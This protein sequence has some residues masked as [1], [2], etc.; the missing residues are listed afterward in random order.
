MGDGHA[1]VLPWM[2]RPRQRHVVAAGFAVV[3]S[4]ALHFVAAER[5]P[6]IPIGRV[7][8][9]RGE[10]RYPELLLGDV[11]RVEPERA[12]RPARFRPE[13]PRRAVESAATGEE[14]TRFLEAELPK[15]DVS[16]PP[17]AGESQA[18]AEPPAA[19]PAKSWEARQEILE[20]Q[21]RIHADEISALPR[22]YEAR[23]E[24]AS[25][26]PDIALPS[27]PSQGAEGFARLAAGL[28]AAAGVSLIRE[29][30]SGLP[31]GGAGADAGAP[32]AGPSALLDEGAG[33]VSAMKPVEQLLAL[34]V[35]VCRPDSEPG[36]QF[37]EVRIARRTD[38]GLPVQA[39]DVLL[40]QDCSESM[41]EP[42]L[43]NCKDGLLRWMDRLNPG[44][45]FDLVGF[46]ENTYRCFGR[47]VE[48]SPSARA[49]ANG[50]VNEMEA[51]GKTDVYASLREALAVRRDPGRPLIA[52]LITD[53][54]PTAGTLDSSEIIERFT[55]EN[56]GRVAFFCVGGGRRV[57]RFLLDLLAYRNRGDSRITQDRFEIP[58]LMQALAAETARP[59]LTDLSYRFAP[60]GE[61]DLYPR[62]LAH[63]YLDRP[64]ILYGRCPADTARLVCQIVGRAG[65]AQHDMVFDLDLGGAKPADGDLPR[66][67]AWQRVYH[68]LGEH[69]QGGRADALAEMRAVADRYR[70]QVPYVAELPAP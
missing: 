32:R 21:D 52:A 12:R 28:P 37:F 20:I 63:L 58:D 64:L 13:D 8:N 55:R 47:W 19:A 9:A 25:A 10:I 51:R 40:V 48:V 50:F 2:D 39:K 38:A 30:P 6:A 24:R 44:D 54:R 27:E 67:W 36:V 43:N 26:A 68:L 69:L 1:R 59:V 34:D 65:A 11:R 14:L 42:K 57:N 61:G 33:D 60:V 4:A 56:D 31:G 46:R 3:A 70:L 17:V 29:L 53:G 16:T 18:I 23:A 5:F 22:R 15:P 7:S 62:R 35:S 49:R 41:T 66:R 45:R